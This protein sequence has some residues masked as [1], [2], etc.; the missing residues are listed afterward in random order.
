MQKKVDWKGEARRTL[1]FEMKIRDIGYKE[2][3]RRL[4][5]MG[6]AETERSVASKVSRGTFSAAFLLQCLR[7]MDVRTLD[8]S[9]GPVTSARED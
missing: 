1:R 4:N 8:V 6:V 2:L 3:V 7:A 5:G 9:G